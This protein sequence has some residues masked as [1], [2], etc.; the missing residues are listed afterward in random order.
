MKK[1][2]KIFLSLSAIII[3][4]AAVSFIFLIK[5]ANRIAKHELDQFLGKNFSV[6][7]VRLKWNKVEAMNVSYRNPDGKTVFHTDSLVLSSDFMGLLKKNYN[8]SSATLINPYLM[9]EKDKE[10]T[11]KNPFP[12]RRDKDKNG[13]SSE[14]RI[15]KV[16]II[17]GSLDYVDE[18]VSGEP[19]IT[20]LRNIDI[21]SENIIFPLQDNFTDYRFTAKVS[22]KLSA[23]IIQSEGKIA[24]KTFDMDSRVKAD[25]LDVTHFKPYFRKKSTVNINR[26]FLDLDMDMKIIS[27]KIDAPGRAVL[28]DLQFESGKGIKEKFLK[29]PVHA[30][31]AFLKDNKDRIAFDFTLQGDLDNP[32]FSLSEGVIDKLTIGL[33]EKLGLPVESISGSIVGLGA[34]GVGQIGKGIKSA[35]EELK[36]VLK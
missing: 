34:E 18:E 16:E 10:G 30:I 23:G 21:E 35:G 22:G 32:K 29:L 4:I 20:E 28:R 33:A 11:F 6:Q 7:E 26:G 13:P 15:Q 17:N 9:L 5:N 8:V 25:N 36:K 31:T 19:V 24:L 27:G 1:G 3:I 12:S 14:F 2:T